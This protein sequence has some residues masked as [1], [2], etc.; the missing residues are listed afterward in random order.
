VFQFV[1]DVAYFIFDIYVVKHQGIVCEHII[2]I[3]ADGLREQ[4]D[5]NDTFRRWE[6]IDLIKDNK[7]CIY[8]CFGNQGLGEVNALKS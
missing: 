2:E 4:T 3:S 7:N 8:Y 6:Y 5:A 1:I